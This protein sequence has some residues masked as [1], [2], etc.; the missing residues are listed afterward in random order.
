MGKESQLLEASA[1]GN[2]NKVEVC[3]FGGREKLL[4]CSIAL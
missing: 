1:S 3:K 4:K 2:A